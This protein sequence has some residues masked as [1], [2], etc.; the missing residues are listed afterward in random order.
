[1]PGPAP[2]TRKRSLHA[3]SERMADAADLHA[4]LAARTGVH[5]LGASAPVFDPAL[6]ARPVN[7]ATLYAPTGARGIRTSR[8]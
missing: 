1:M 6:G 3:V 2:A 4:D 8:S 5:I 7:R